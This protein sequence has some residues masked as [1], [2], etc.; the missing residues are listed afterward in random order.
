MRLKPERIETLSNLIYEALA[1]NAEITVNEGREKIVGLVRR[2][3]TEDLTAEDEIEEEARRLLEQHKTE[4]Q[5]KG[6]SYEK[7]FHKAKQ[8]LALERKMVI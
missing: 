8:K 7:L 2:I 6:A 3:I 5:R 4:I 1:A